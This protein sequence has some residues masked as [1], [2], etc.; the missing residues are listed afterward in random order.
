M[1]ESKELYCIKSYKL[2]VHGGNNIISG[3]EPF[4]KGEYSASEGDVILKAIYN[5]KNKNIPEYILLEKKEDKF[6]E[7]I[8][9]IE[10]DCNLNI[11]SKTIHNNPMFTFFNPSCDEKELKKAIAS[12]DNVDLDK[13]VKK[14]N[15]FDNFGELT[16]ERYNERI[17]ADTK[18]EKTEDEIYKIYKKIIN[19]IKNS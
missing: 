8:T 17:M 3:T 19:Y 5:I 2:F 9:G 16:L 7:F 1:K 18:K 15:D 14:L 11:I 13:Y 6:Y 10:I 12:Y 4:R